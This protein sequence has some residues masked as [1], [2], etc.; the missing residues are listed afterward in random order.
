MCD[1]SSRRS[2]ICSGIDNIFKQNREHTHY[3]W[4][5]IP[6]FFLQGSCTTA[7]RIKKKE[8]AL[9]LQDSTKR[10]YSKEVSLRLNFQKFQECYYKSNT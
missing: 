9:H 3:S 5:Q 1:S 2:H 4:I 7:Y 8:L 6:I 10:T